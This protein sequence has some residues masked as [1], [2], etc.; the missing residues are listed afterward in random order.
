MEKYTVLIDLKTQH[1]ISMSITSKSISNFDSFS[2]NPSKC[3][4]T[5][6]EYSKTYIKKQ[7]SWNN[8]K[9]KKKY[10][11]FQDIT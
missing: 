4:F 2:H 5:L 11:E 8:F 9:K 10:E 6:K 1:S 3:F 7:N